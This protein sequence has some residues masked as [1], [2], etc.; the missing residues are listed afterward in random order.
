M[1]F[2]FLDPQ[3]PPSWGRLSSF[4]LP[5]VLL[6]PV[7]ASRGFMFPSCGMLRSNPTLPH[8]GVMMFHTPSPSGVPRKEITTP[9]IANDVL[10]GSGLQFV[11]Q[12]RSSLLYNL[13]PHFPSDWLRPHCGE[14]WSPGKRIPSTYV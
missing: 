14:T 7:D 9:F 13:V 12:A 10:Y 5:L 4:L 2:F 11:C 8:Q 1:G 6:S 3:G